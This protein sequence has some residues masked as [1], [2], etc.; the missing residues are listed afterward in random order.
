ML[1]QLSQFVTRTRV[2]DVS[3]YPDVENQINAIV[4]NALSGD[5]GWVS[6]NLRHLNAMRDLGPAGEALWEEAKALR[7]AVD[8]RGEK[9]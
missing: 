2:V 6:H 9:K 1:D 8:I 7:V 5:W 3:F 4:P